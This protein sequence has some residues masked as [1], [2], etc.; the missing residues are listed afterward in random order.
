MIYIIYLIL[1][2]ENLDMH[3]SDVDMV[4][5][6]HRTQLE[7]IYI[8]LWSVLSY[9]AG[10]NLILKKKDPFEEDMSPNW[11]WRFRLFYWK[12]CWLILMKI[13]GINLGQKLN[14]YTAELDSTDV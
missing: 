5:D 10:F 3:F 11:L 13:I 6:K 1:I 7:S 14:E 8:L 4:D 9:S 2:D 12:W